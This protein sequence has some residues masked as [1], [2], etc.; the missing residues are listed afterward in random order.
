[1]RWFIW[2]I[3][4]LVFAYVL[5]WGPMQAAASLREITW[6]AKGRTLSLL[7]LHIWSI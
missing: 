1:M 2:D 7:A 5:S 4:I 3:P 6:V